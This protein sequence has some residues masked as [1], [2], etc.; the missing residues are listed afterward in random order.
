MAVINSFITY[1]ITNAGG[2]VDVDSPIQAYP[3]GVGTEKVIY[4][5]ASSVTLAAS[6]VFTCTGTLSEGMRFNIMYDGSAGGNDLNG[7]SFTIFGITLTQAQLNSKMIITV[8]YDGSAF[9]TN[10]AV[11]FDSLGKAINGVEVQTLDANG[12]TITLDP[13]INN[14]YQYI[15]GTATLVASWSITGTGTAVN[16]GF[17]V[18][19]D[20]ALTVGANA[21]TIFGQGLTSDEALNGMVSVFVQYDVT[22]TTYR[23]Q[24][25]SGSANEA[26]LYQ[27]MMVYA[28]ATYGN[29]STGTANRQDLPFATLAAA[30]T[31][32][33]ALSPTSTVKA[34]IKGWGLF[35]EQLVVKNNVDYDL[36]NAYVTLAS[37]NGAFTITDG[38]ADAVSTIYGNPTITRTGTGT[39][40]VGAIGISGTN[41]VVTIY[42]GNISS[43]TGGASDIAVACSAGVLN[44]YFNE[45]T[46]TVGNA[47]IVSSG[48]TVYANGK[49]VT[50]IRNCIS[51]TAGSVTAEVDEFLCTETTGTAVDAIGV[52]GSGNINIK[53]RKGTYNNA[54]SEFFRYNTS[55]NAIVE[56]TGTVECDENFIKTDSSAIGI[57]EVKGGK[58]E[59]S[60]IQGVYIANVAGTYYIHDAQFKL[61]G[62]DADFMNIVGAT[63]TQGVK[64]L[65][66]ETNGTGESFTSGVAVNL[67]NYGGVVTNLVKNANVTQLVGA[68]TVSAS[69][70]V[71]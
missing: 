57:C 3:N 36:T 44:L 27:N 41:S 37:G 69:V 32:A 15:T 60:S 13:N 52:S 47:G 48:G 22:N 38:G 20:A 35:P 46:G 6:Q 21:V 8:D 7:N 28:D 71:L 55:G 51:C 70:V 61:T 66:I 67:L 5:T 68:E 29:D 40:P 1:A 26:N 25:M 49:K 17:W 4:I 54:T 56:C 43:S 65:V 11:S 34:R 53:F 50:S 2:T 58:W 18:F 63:S 62:T 12:G 39:T 19:Y 42:A 9:V 14:K 23:V 24:K 31:A 16:H 30:N 10:V 59:T 33:L 45:I 64:N